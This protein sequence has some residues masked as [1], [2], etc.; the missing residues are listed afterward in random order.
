MLIRFKKN[1][2]INYWIFDI[3]KL[4][5]LTVFKWSLAW[6]S[7]KYLIILIYEAMRDF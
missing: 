6:F 7:A 4:R 3:E 5:M 2:K 1:G